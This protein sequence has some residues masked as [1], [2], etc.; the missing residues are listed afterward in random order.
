MKRATL[1]IAAALLLQCRTP[2]STQ[3]IVASVYPI[4]FIAARLAGDDFEVAE[5]T[6]P[7][8]EPHDVE[9]TPRQVRQIEEAKLVLFIDSGFQPAVSEAAGGNQ[10]A[11]NVL[12]LEEVKSSLIRNGD[13]DPHIWLDPVLVDDFAFAIAARLAETSRSNGP[14]ILR[15]MEKLRTEL[16]GLDT[17]FRS[18]LADCDRHMIVTSHGA[19]AYLARR[20][21]LTQLSITGVDP[22][23]EPSPARLAEVAQM[24]LAANTTTVFAE[25]LVSSKIADTL[26][27]E[28][29]ANV[30][31]LDPIEGPPPSGDYLSAMRSNLNAL[32]QGLGCR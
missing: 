32:R 15:R 28:I 31:V 19:F 27:K 14:E 26:A 17:A 21:G 13:V 10:N 23:A 2:G 25:R 11:I 29:H 9:L 22:E 12:Q 20:Y 30:A 3:V 4:E 6:K 7:G 16:K 18:G 1:L 24:A 8:A 5:L